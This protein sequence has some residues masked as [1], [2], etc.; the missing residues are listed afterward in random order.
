[1]PS[2]VR[3]IARMSPRN[4]YLRVAIAGGIGFV[5]IAASKLWWSWLISVVMGWDV[6]GFIML[7]LAWSVIWTAD[8]EETQRRA[9]AQDPG[10][11]VVYVLV[12]LTASVSL[13]A[14]VALLR[15]SSFD[16]VVPVYLCAATVVVSWM[17][18]HTA[19]T[20][21]YAHLY[22]RDD[23]DEGVGGIDLP[24]HTAA[25]YFDFAYFAFTLG[26][27][28]QVSDATVTSSQIRRT[29]L[30][31][32]LMSFAFNTAIMAFVLNLMFGSLG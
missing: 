29:V 17:L 30:L 7:V 2:S 23:D 3:H 9:A 16:G 25:T 12:L 31:H 21:R 15:H 1:M 8:A 20:L 13:F 22:Y 6:G 18:T 11:R 14:A 5:A 24:G 27:C 32:A 26:M 19:F 10:R 4:A 28:F